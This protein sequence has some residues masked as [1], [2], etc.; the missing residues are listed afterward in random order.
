MMIQIP[1]Q[2]NFLLCLIPRFIGVQIAQT[3]RL[4]NVNIRE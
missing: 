4:A 3:H 2:T 1:E